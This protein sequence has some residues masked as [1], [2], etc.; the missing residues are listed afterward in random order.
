MSNIRE[1]AKKAN[2]SIATVS[3]ILRNDTSFHTSKKT[4]DAVYRA[5]KE[6]DYSPKN[7]TKMTNIG[8][9]L[10]ITSEKYSDP[11]CTTILS[12]CEKEAERQNT[13]ISQVRHYSE[14][15]NP[16]VLNQFINCGL[17]GLIIME[18]LPD[19]MLNKIKKKI[20]HIIYVDYDEAIESINTVGFDHRFANITAF[21]YLVE[22]GYKRIAVITESSPVDP[23]ESSVRLMSY[24]EIL[25][26]N[27]IKY[28]PSLIRDCRCD[29][30][31]C[32]NQT[33]EL[34]KLKNP[35]D[36]IFV[37]SDTLANA[38]IGELKKL[39]YDCPKDIGVMGFNNLPI[40]AHT[41]PT[42]TTV[43]IPMVDI[44]KKTINRLVEIMNK[45]DNYNLKISFPTKLIVRESTRRIK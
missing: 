21:N 29:I 26:Q 14:L 17:K 20:P 41:N 23:V 42:L 33:R 39:G 40:S 10:S 22:C 25:R 3:R 24:R 34:M 27:N 19:D 32:V 6:L 43:D 15:T 9:I 16:L 12:A 7:K 37:G 5:I 2:V 38:T 44:G 28:D 36:V 8:C 13:I 11:F 18:K 30:D 31:E 4:K 35:P 1:V 45:K